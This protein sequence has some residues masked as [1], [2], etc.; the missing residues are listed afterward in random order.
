MIL[1]GIQWFEMVIY[2]HIYA[3]EWCKSM[4]QKLN[5]DEY[6]Y[7]ISKNLNIWSCV[8]QYNISWKY[9]NLMTAKPE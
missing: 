9:I 1:D 8:Q 5:S 3:R 2:E 7:H 4:L 6:S